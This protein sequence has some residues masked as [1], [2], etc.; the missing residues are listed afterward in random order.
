MCCTIEPL[1][2]YIKIITSVMYMQN[3]QSRVKRKKILNTKKK[4]QNII[5]NKIQ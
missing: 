4:N 3:D 2:A 1:H 5:N